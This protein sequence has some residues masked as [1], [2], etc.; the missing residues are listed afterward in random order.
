M[1]VA[2]RGESVVGALCAWPP[3]EFATAVIN[4]AVASAATMAPLLAAVVKVVAVC[5]DEPDRGTGI[6]T[7]LLRSC[8]RL[9]RE[10]GYRLMYGVVEHADLA[11]YYDSRGFEVLAV[12][13]R[14]SV[15]EF[16][17]ISAGIGGG[18]KRLF[19]RRLR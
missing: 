2:V 12:G 1:L 4:S 6:G 3:F 19:T 10:A 5:V 16:T 18:D 13:K 17:G 15:R 9:Y 7:E 8:T 14:I 11:E